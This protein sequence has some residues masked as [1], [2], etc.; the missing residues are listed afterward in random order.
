MQFIYHNFK[1]IVRIY[2]VI[3]L[4]SSLLWG[5]VLG[6]VRGLVLVLGMILNHSINKFLKDSSRSIFGEKSA[7][8]K[9]P[10]GAINCGLFIDPDNPKRPSSSYGF[11]SGH[12]QMSAFIST[13]VIMY[14][15]NQDKDKSG[16][17]KKTVPWSSYLIMAII[18][19]I[20]MYMRVHLGCHT[21]GQVIGGALI[22]VVIGYVFLKLTPRMS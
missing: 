7:F 6:D 10:K 22:G 13:V 16:K 11:P 18:P 12:S 8:G 21:V 17:N 2:E 15:L 20:S 14:L 1:D 9:R 4:V 3:I 19:L 5:V